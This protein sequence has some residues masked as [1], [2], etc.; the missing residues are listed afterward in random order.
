MTAHAQKQNLRN[1]P[2]QSCGQVIL[3]AISRN[4]QKSTFHNNIMAEI[5]VRQRHLAPF[6][7]YLQQLNNNLKTNL[8]TI[9]MIKIYLIH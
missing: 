9:K 6:Y 2:L 7:Q 5:L 8:F 1:L 4:N 3:L